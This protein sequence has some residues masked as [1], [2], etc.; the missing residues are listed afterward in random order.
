MKEGGFYGGE[1]EQAKKTR[2]GKVGGKDDWVSGAQSS[3]GGS[4]L[5]SLQVQANL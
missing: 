3:P 5:V 2:L 1:E 4:G